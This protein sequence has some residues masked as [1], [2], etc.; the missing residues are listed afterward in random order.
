MI[1]HN[2]SGITIIYYCSK[3]HRLANDLYCAVCKK[4][5]DLGDIR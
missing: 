1:S 4:Q 2:S 3:D 5:Y